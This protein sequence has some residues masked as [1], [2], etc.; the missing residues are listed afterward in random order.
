MNTASPGLPFVKEK[1]LNLQ[2]CVICQNAKDKRGDKKLTSNKK[3]KT[4]LDLMLKSSSRQFF[5]GL[6][7]S[8]LND[9][10]YKVYIVYSIKY[11][12]IVIHIMLN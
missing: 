7:L 2:K 10:K 1:K 3:R 4:N 12:G 11:T 8:E 5:S 6:N 9:I